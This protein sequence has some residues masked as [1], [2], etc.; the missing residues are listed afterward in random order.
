MS[1]EARLR[2]Y[3][4]RL[5]IDLRRARRRVSELEGRDEEPIAIVGIGCRYPGGADSPERLWELIAAG[6]DAIS[7]F[8]EDRGWDL[9]GLASAEPGQPGTGGVREGGFLEDVAGFDPGFFGIGPREAAALDPQQRLLLEVAW[10]ALERS[11][12]EPRSLRKA[13]VG[14]FAGVMSQEYAAAEAGIVAGMTSSVVSG[15]LAYSLGFEGPAI[16]LDTACSSSLVAMHLAVQ[17]L[18]RG[19]CSLALAGGATVLST[20]KPLVF[21]AMQGGLAPDGRCKAFAE[22][23][24]GVGW[25]E[26]A[27]VLVLERLT[28]AERHG[29]PVLATIRASAINQDGASNGL[30]APN[31][32]AQER[33]IRTALAASGLAP[34]DVDAVEA[35]GTGTMLGDPIEAGA[36][37]ATY[38]RERE[39][40]LLLGSVKS[41]IGHTQAAAGVAGVIKMVMAM[42]EGVLPRTLHAEIPSSQIKWESGE[43]ELLRE[44]RAWPQTE[45]PRRAAISSFGISGTNAHVI[46]EGPPPVP[47]SP[48]A[49]P[50]GDPALPGELLL[51]LAARNEVALAAQARDLAARAKG[52]P[53]LRLVD[54]AWSRA[55]TRTSFER[56]AVVVEP[57]REAA[58]EALDALTRGAE[59]PSLVVAAAGSD[60]DP[61][62]LFGGQGSQWPGMAVELLDGSPAFA[63]RMRECEA[64][65]APFT[66]WS[67]LETLRGPGEIWLDRLDVVQP[68]LFAVMVSLAELWRAHG[69][70]PAAVAGHSQGEIAAAH[71]AGGLSLED[72]ARVVALRARAMTQIAGRGGMLAVGLG[73][74]A[75]AERLRPFGERLALAAIN[76]PASQIVSGEPAALDELAAACEADGVRS[77]RV[78]VDYAAHSPQIDELADEL[79]ESFA[80]I[81]PRA[82]TIPFFSTVT[83]G[84]LDT[85]QLGPEYWRRN[86]RDTVLFEPALRALLGSGHRAFVE[87]APHPVLAFGVNE[88]IDAAAPGAATAV[89]G[90]LRRDEGGPRRF[91]LS[92]AEA[93]AHGIDID[94]EAIF[95]G[96]GA[97]V[98][99]LPTYPFQRERY[100]H[101]AELDGADPRALGQAPAGHPL[102]G[103]AIALAGGKRL[104]TGRVS[105]ASHPW[106]ADHRVHG[107]ALA[108][109]SLFLELAWRAG[110]EVGCEAVDGLELDQPLVLPEEGSVQLQVVVG[111]PDAAGARAVAVHSRREP[112]AGEGEGE[113]TPNAR[114]L[115]RPGPPESL[116]GAIAWPPPGAEALDVATIYEGFAD[117]GVDLGASFQ[118]LVA[119]WRE[120][121]AVH[122]EV[123][124]PPAREEEAGRFCLHPALLQAGL[125]LA[126][127]SGG[128]DGAEPE[129]V[130]AAGTASLQEGGA[131][132]L[133]VSVVPG[134]DGAAIS[135]RD[136]DGAT[137]GRIDGVRTSSVSLERL[138]PRSEQPLAI[139]WR[140]LAPPATAVE[141]EP[142]PPVLDCSELD[143]KGELPGV[144]LD[145]AVQVLRRL[146]EWIEAGPG[147]G[148][149]L[150]VLTRNAV[151]VGPGESP[152]LRMAPL[153]GL[154]RVAQAENPGRLVVADLDD[155]AD[156]AAERATLLAA[157][158]TEPQLAYRG[159]RPLVPRLT[160][161]AGFP[162]AK[163]GQLDPESTVLFC[164]DAD[165]LAAP[166]ARRLLDEGGARHL[167]TVE[168]GEAADRGRLRALLDEI[169]PGR[170]LAAVLHAS[171]ELDE[172]VVGSLDRQQLEGA[173][174]PE[175]DAAWNLH[176]LTSGL[177][178]AQFVLCSPVGGYATDV[179][180]AAQATVGSFFDA[181]AATRRDA[182]LAAA[183]LV[184]GPLDFAALRGQ[185]RDGVLPA[186][187]RD[188]VPAQAPR[189]RRDGLAARLLAA[190]ERERPAI[191]REVVCEQVAAVLGHD[192][193]RDVDPELPFLDLGFDSVSAVALRNRLNAVAG[194]TL[195]PTLAFDYPTPAAL[196]DYLAAELLP[197]GSRNAA[198]E[199]EEAL[200]GL[201]AKLAAV[202]GDSG[203]RERVS[204]RL[205]AALADLAG[206]A[207]AAEEDEA[208]LS[209]MSHDE[210]FALID[211]EVDD[212]Q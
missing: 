183:S 66:D 22:G 3:L 142:E 60:R 127:A 49:A 140:E 83:G 32:P 209:S 19:E 124:L 126:A 13:P 143:L 91:A 207:G 171:G 79:A 24:D 94:W 7:P 68:A 101:D 120:G 201:E 190:A 48:V 151:A 43:V 84:E 75:L 17:S 85:A 210:V 9:E 146:R 169:P 6:R 123:D 113:W 196:A 97:E 191:A 186:I 165:G 204:M 147:E 109:A 90:T 25:A 152:D 202:D 30:T 45:R 81:S 38:G 80:P 67:L 99:D 132:A 184:W 149:R 86:L 10:E 163:S 203:M 195:P 51:P 88:T 178:L 166:L 144:A 206:A 175:L 4:E 122:A 208:D 89:L 188:L 47:P 119:L 53:E 12:I 125:Q 39:R 61:V 93:H 130:A 52:D 185:A 167:L 14:V 8:P 76:G 134:P 15:R 187:M 114:G 33:L 172:G 20:P 98:V 70:E 21:F 110:E 107:S 154:L 11:R 160:R 69:V 194:L 96:S 37:L 87:I 176:E 121:E 102:L 36:L 108:P 34:G 170:P 31:G 71:V 77:R 138:G 156:P 18:R 44:A 118:G 168:T 111:E 63:A 55:S 115:L 62:F 106:L 153:W 95:A 137:V 103:A 54:I 177:P 199:L 104:L 145:L 5:T 58:L 197:G 26:G 29:H 56:R 46:V 193:P 211:E 179:G 72:A 50:N 189:R 182:G 161:R 27:G 82:G 35:H 141:P 135:L 105:L 174:R 181:L 136:G 164:G 64:A 73:V 65:L 150:L 128:A 205:R 2:Q 200:A 1:E 162:P 173:V 133:R 92:L 59:H 78:A 116:P 40:P 131:A 192:S 100:W 148:E 129:L 28:D 159:G 198:D 16:S 74:E 41:N 112:G 117:R 155:A 212:G 180:G 158:V 42:R 139:E 23:A 57:D 157:G